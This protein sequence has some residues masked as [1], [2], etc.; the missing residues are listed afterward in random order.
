MDE[1]DRHIAALEARIGDLEGRRAARCVR[2]RSASTLFG[3][4]LLDIALGRDADGRVGMRAASSRSATSPAG[5]SPW[6]ASPA[7]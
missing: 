4:P 1:R 7:A 3:L 5:S 2:R 6:A